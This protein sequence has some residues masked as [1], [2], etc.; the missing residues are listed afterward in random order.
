M[1]AFLAP[2]IR[3]RFAGER[4]AAINLPGHL[5][6]RIQPGFERIEAGI[7]KPRHAHFS[8]YVSVML[9]GGY[10]QSGYFG[11]VRLEPGDVLVQPVLD[12]HE[13]WPRPYE[14]PHILRLA[15]EPDTGLGGVY[16]PRDIDQVIRI[17]ERD[18]AEA[19]ALLAH[20]LA[21]TEMV[22]VSMHDWPDLLAAALRSGP[23]GIA[24]WARDHGLSRETVARGFARCW[25][26]SPQGFAGELRAREAW[27]RSATGSDR[28]ADIA[29]DLGFADQPHMT[30]AV[31]TLTGLPPAA[32]RR[33]VRAGTVIL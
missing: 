28:L 22:A 16:R 10:A 12:R 3:A 1:T 21:G 25:G 30:R 9:D 4:D 20:M 24:S 15:W 7:G 26:V 23:V 5:F 14:A 33:R 8:A 6:R 29:A 32:W 2:S 27:L 17:A 19:S 31:R 11:R 18:P 13:S